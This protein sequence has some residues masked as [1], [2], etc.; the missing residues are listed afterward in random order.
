MSAY[1]KYADKLRE[2]GYTA[3]SNKA[4]DWFKD[5]LNKTRI[6]RNSIIQK[7]NKIGKPTVGK[8]YTYFYNPKNEAKLPYYDG[9]PLIIL[10]GPAKGGWYGLNLHYLDSGTRAQF[11]SDLEDLM[12]NTRYDETTRIRITYERLMRSRKL[13]VASEAFKH[14]LGAHVTSGIVEIPAEDWHVAIMLPTAKWRGPQAR[15]RRR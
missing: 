10:V 1:R 6:S 15:S 13:N 5:Q 3:N 7:G 14:Y 12:N 2:Q 8:M 11:F 9:M 4:R